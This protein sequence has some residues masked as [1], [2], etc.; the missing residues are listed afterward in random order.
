MKKGVLLYAYNTE[1]NYINLA[2]ICAKRIKKY[3]QLPITL[4][5]DNKNT[6]PNNID[7]FDNILEFSDNI[8]QQKRF[9]NGANSEVYYWKNS[10][11][12]NSFDITPYD[13]TLVLDVDYI[14]SSNFLVQCMDLQ[15]D[16]LIFKEFNDLSKTR[17]NVEFSHISNFSIPFYWATVFIFEKNK[18]NKIFFDLIKFIKNNWDYYRLIYQISD[19]KFRNDFAFSIAI[20]ILSGY[21]PKS[22]V[23]T[24]PGKIHFVQDRDFLIN[25]KDNSLVFL[26]QDEASKTNYSPIKVNN[27]DVHVMN[28][29]SLLDTFK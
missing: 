22:F 17:K 2:I 12:V 18:K 14:V 15:S 27:L 25:A 21:L 20:H 6:I 11:R 26:V 3:L 19:P 1:F 24:I 23:D 10:S 28:K 8:E 16:F 29:F 13:K 4:V 7:L 5:T 9:Y